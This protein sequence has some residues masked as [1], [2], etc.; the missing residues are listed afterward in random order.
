MSAWPQF[1][2]LYKSTAVI[3]ERFAGMRTEN[4]FLYEG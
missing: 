1:S 4:G 2:N 3:F